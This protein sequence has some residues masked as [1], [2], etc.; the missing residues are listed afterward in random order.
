MISSYKVPFFA[1]SAQNNKYTQVSW[2]IRQDKG[3]VG[4]MLG[5]YFPFLRASI[6]LDYTRT[7]TCV[8]NQKPVA[9]YWRSVLAPGKCCAGGDPALQAEPRSQQPGAC[10]QG[11]SWQRLPGGLYSAGLNSFNLFPSG[12]PEDFI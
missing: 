10:Q 2:R 4:T 5:R 8:K 3:G 1:L 11:E 6:V 7:N 9:V 12:H